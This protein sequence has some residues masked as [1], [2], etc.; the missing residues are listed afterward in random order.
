M[1][2][3][4]C[5]VRFPG[6]HGNPGYG[7][8]F[9]SKMVRSTLLPNPGPGGPSGENQG[10]LH[11]AWPGPFFGSSSQILGTSESMKPRKLSLD[12]FT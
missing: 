1:K 3:S 12:H 8:T 6:V 10:V 7:R 4:M 9:G 11:L 5:F 2:I